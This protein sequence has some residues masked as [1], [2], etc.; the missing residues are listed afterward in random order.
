MN[1]E[2]NQLVVELNQ[3]A[4]ALQMFSSNQ[5]AA[6]IESLYSDRYR[7]FVCWMAAMTMLGKSDRAREYFKP[8]ELMDAMTTPPDAAQNGG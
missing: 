6:E 4:G 7:V 2:A 1:R 3:F 5:G 8:D